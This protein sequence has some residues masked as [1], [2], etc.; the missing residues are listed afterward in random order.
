[1]WF[2]RFLWCGVNSV[3]CA[4]VFWRG[5]FLGL[6]IA[7]FQACC[8]VWVSGLF[9]GLGGLL[10]FAGISLSCGWCNIDC[11]RVLGVVIAFVVVSVCVELWVYVIIIWLADLGLVAGFTGCLWVRF[12]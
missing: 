10:W 8:C 9:G 5:W 11:E 6:A 7:W 12:G 3:G 4:L 1:M 2:L